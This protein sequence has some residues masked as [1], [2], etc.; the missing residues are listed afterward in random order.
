MIRRILG[1]LKKAIFRAIRPPR[2]RIGNK[3]NHNTTIDLL[4]P[5]VISIGNN[6]VSG[7][8]SII[9]AHDAS[10]LIHTGEYRVEPVRIGDNVFLGAG[11]IVLP[12][13]T[14]GDNVI[15][16]AGS[17]VTE[18][19]PPNSVVAG[20]PA[21]V[22]ETVDEYVRKCRERNVLY[23]PPTA[24]SK[25]WRNLALTPNDISEFQSSTVKEMKRRFG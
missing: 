24:F 19:V 12:G 23:R 11:A 25:V 1:S 3:K 21:R 5:Q 6:F 16:G 15:V 20:N 14:I 4:I 8:Q 2:Y 7:P 9:L 17:I 22:L 18:D 13:V 10:L